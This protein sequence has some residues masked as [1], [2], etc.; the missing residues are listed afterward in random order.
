MKKCKFC[1]SELVPKKLFCPSCGKAQDE[2]KVRTV[3]SSN[4]PADVNR[5]LE[6]SGLTTEKEKSQL[7]AELKGGFKKREEATITGNVGNI[8]GIGQV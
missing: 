3:G 2:I 5:I 4:R 8:G 6:E 1:K 7:L